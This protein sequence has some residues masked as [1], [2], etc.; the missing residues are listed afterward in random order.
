M[1]AGWGS[2]VRLAR[3]DN[4]GMR[5]PR[6][7][8][9]LL[10]IS[11][12]ALAACSSS[13]NEHPSP[14]PSMPV[15]LAPPS[16]APSPSPTQ[17]PLLGKGTYAAKS[18]ARQITVYKGPQPGHVRYVLD[19]RNPFGQEISMLV[20]DARR[21]AKGT[22]WYQVLLPTAPN[23]S[24]GWVKGSDVHLTPELDKVVVDLSKR[25]LKYYRGKRLVETFSVGVGLPQFPTTTGTFYV[26]AHVPQASPTGPYGIYALGL[27]G[28]SKVLTE[29]PGG[30]RMAI[31]GTANPTDRGNTVSHGC[32]RVYNPDMQKLRHLP[33]GTPVIIKA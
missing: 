3:A 12:L 18:I 17:D 32:V 19:T 4:R 8:I 24:T 26:W 14:A 31:H 7:L 5:P 6:N 16:V 30:G 20:T 33:M 11:G 13:P 22:A 1:V 9:S 27:S 25:T 10:L 15:A 28:F 2:V 29:W 21:D 23:D